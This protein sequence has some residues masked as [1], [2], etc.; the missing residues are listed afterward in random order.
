MAPQNPVSSLSSITTPFA[1]G[2]KKGVRA[3]ALFKRV[4]SLLRFGHGTG[5][6]VL[7]EETVDLIEM[8]VVAL[9][10]ATPTANPD[11][12]TALIDQRAAGASGGALTID[13][14]EV[15]G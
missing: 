13:L 7:F 14:P 8:R 1:P 10:V 9:P 12:V 11:H 5:G 6:F 3:G 15:A 2:K 4:R